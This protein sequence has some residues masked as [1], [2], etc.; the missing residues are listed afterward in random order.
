MGFVQ[1]HET[2]SELPEETRAFA[3]IIASM[4]EEADAINSYE[5]RMVVEKNGIARAI[6]GNAQQEEFKHF[7]MEL[8]FLLRAKPKWRTIL[9]GILFK[10]GDIVALGSAAEKSAG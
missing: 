10:D 1:Y 9:Q 4:A 2:A 3:R 6:M 7:G 5:Q 8:E